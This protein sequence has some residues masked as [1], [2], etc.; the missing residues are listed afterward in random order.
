MEGRKVVLVTGASSGLGK[1]ICTHLAAKGHAVYGTSRR[2]GQGG[3]FTLLPM[4]VTDA[5]SVEAAVADILAREGR[6]DVLVNNAGQ[7]IQG[8][9]EDIT[10][11]LAHRVL[12]TNLVG[13]LRVSRAVLPSM[14]GNK[15]GLIINISSL[16]AN[17]GLPFR[18]L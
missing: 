10:P 13:P 14:R 3:N 2:E 18:G 7:G 11:E 8:A 16:A 4:D 5:A 1:A 12:D 6:L 9:V 15:R 17:F